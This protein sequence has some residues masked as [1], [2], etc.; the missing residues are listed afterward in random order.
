MDP[1]GACCEESSSPPLQS[2]TNKTVFF[3]LS[4]GGATEKTLW[5]FIF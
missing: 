5:C 4:V 1:L 3:S 2:G